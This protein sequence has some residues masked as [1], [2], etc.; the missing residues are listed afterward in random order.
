MKLLRAKEESPQISVD[1]LI[2]KILKNACNLG[3]EIHEHKVC[4]M[5]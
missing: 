4:E 3:Y 2:N 1:I 5:E